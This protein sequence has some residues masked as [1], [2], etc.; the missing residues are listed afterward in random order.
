MIS[1]CAE[2]WVDQWSQTALPDDTNV[3]SVCTTV[4]SL[5]F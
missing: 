1:V 2:S 3:L 5:I 4:P